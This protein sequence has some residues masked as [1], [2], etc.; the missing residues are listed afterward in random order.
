MHGG[1]ENFD[2]PIKEDQWIDLPTQQQTD[3]NKPITYIQTSIQKSPMFQKN[4]WL[5]SLLSNQATTTISDYCAVTLGYQARHSKLENWWLSDTYSVTIWAESS[6]VSGSRFWSLSIAGRV[7]Q[8]SPRSSSH[9]YKQTVQWAV[10]AVQILLPLSYKFPVVVI[11]ASVKQ[12]VINSQSYTCTQCLEWT[13]CVCSILWRLL[14][15][16]HIH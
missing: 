10:R 9:D 6:T 11:P 13:G 14:S 12:C 4:Q 1:E 15:F 8:R 16:V 5:L 2:P 3:N 7:A